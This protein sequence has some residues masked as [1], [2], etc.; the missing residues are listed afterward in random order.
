RNQ[1]DHS[2]GATMQSVFLNDADLG[3]TKIGQNFRWL[4]GSTTW[5]GFSNSDLGADESVVN[6]GDSGAP[7]F[8]TVSP[9]NTMPAVVGINWFELTTAQGQGVGSGSTFVPGY[10]ATGQPTHFSL[11]TL[12]NAMY[13]SG[14]QPSLVFIDPTQSRGDF[15]LDGTVTTG[16]IQAMLTALA[17]PSAFEALHGVSA[18]YFATMADVNKDG[19]VNDADIQA[20]I[21]MLTS[22]IAG[23]SVSAVPEP[24]TAILL[25]LGAWPIWRLARR[26]ARLLGSNLTQ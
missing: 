15:N 1:I 20:L 12:E 14:E 5:K 13:G 6:P 3:D 18:S 8:I 23:G 17:N 9:G 2:T 10:T 7:N 4:F 16:D 21:S 26:N 25:L 22:G 19:L 11:G 24:S